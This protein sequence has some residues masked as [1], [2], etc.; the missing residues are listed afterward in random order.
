MHYNVKTTDFNM[1]PDVSE[2]LDV[3]LSALEKYLSED[4]EDA[5]KCDVE[6]GRA[7]G[8]QRTGNIFRAEV[9][10]LIGKKMFRAEAVG[11]SMNA[12]IDKMRDEIAK[13]LRRDK[14]R[15]F[16]LFKKGGERIKKMLR[17]GR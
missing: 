17:F 7:V 2:Y 1:T 15:R 9:N 16:A 6:L 4:S 11:E 14:R 13:R 12:A 5:V 10:V 8:G 3:K